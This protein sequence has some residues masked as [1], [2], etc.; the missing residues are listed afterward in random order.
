VK[1]IIHIPFLKDPKKFSRKPILSKEIWKNLAKI[2]G[3]K[4]V[5]P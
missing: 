4:E 5:S 2:P 3:K 1:I